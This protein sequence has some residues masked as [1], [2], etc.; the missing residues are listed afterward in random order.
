MHCKFSQHEKK[1][2]K[3][4]LDEIAVPK[5][6]QSRYLGRCYQENELIDEDVTHRIKTRCLKWR[7]ATMI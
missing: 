1:E 7:S 2:V 6:K 3:V 5:C 4:R